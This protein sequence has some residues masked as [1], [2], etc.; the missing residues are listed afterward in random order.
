M[1]FTTRLCMAQ[2]IINTKTQVQNWLESIEDR[3]IGEGIKKWLLDNN[4]AGFKSLILP[5][6]IIAMRGIPA[7]IVKVINIR[8]II[9]D[10]TRTFYTVLESLNFYMTDDNN[11]RLVLDEFPELFGSEEEYR[12]F[13]DNSIIGE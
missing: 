4:K 2:L 13:M 5:T 6:D 7:E 9:Y 11:T 8:K 12:Q 1:R 10:I 3:T